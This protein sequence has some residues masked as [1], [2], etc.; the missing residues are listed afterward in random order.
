MEIFGPFGGETGSVHQRA[1]RAEGGKVKGTSDVALCVGE[2][3]VAVTQP[4]LLLDKRG[5]NQRVALKKKG[6]SMGRK[7]MEK[8]EKRA[9][10]E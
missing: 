9:K 7:R 6:K 3:A 10:K 8:K 4:V 1:H 2:A 5:I